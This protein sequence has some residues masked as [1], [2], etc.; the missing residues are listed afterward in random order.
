MSVLVGSVGVV[1]SGLVSVVS[2]RYVE[3]AANHTRGVVGRVGSA[4][5]V[6]LGA[7]SDRF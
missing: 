4:A 2:A 7:V 6:A 3:V 5:R 1:G